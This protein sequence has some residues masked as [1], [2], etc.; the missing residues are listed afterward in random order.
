MVTNFQKDVMIAVCCQNVAA[1][2]DLFKK[3]LQKNY[4]LVSVESSNP[5]ANKMV[6]HC[7]NINEL[8]L[9]N[10]KTIIRDEEFGA[11]VALGANEFYIKDAAYRII[12]KLSKM[13]VINI[14]SIEDFCIINDSFIIFMDNLIK[15]GIIYLYEECEK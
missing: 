12:M 7:F 15:S 6:L 10:Y 5:I 14:E 4:D 13:S 9:F 11:V 3:N 1:I 8:Y 2:V